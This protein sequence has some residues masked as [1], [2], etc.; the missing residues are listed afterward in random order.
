MSHEYGRLLNSTYTHTV[1]T[2]P[3]FVKKKDEQEKGS[4]KRKKGGREKKSPH[5]PYN[6]GQVDSLL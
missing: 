3:F 4:K 6:L 2:L 1:H 5:S